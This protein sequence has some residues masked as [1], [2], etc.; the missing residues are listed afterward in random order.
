MVLAWIMSLRMEHDGNVRKRPGVYTYGRLAGSGHR[1]ALAGQVGA[2]PLPAAA[3][4]RTIYSSYILQT[5]VAGALSML[6]CV[7]RM[8][9]SRVCIVPGAHS[10]WPRSVPLVLLFPLS[11][12]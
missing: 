7:H 11:R 9:P 8:Q 2:W 5:N 6:L 1:S 3:Q 4:T 10:K 12:I